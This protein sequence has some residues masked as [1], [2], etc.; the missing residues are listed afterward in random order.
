MIKIFLKKLIL[1]VPLIII[2]AVVNYGI[3]PGGIFNTS[4]S[5]LIAK[6]L[7]S[8]KNAAN[9][10]N[11]DERAFQ[12]YYIQ[13]LKKP[14][15]VVVLGSS[16]SMGVGTSILPANLS[17]FNS[18]VS[19]GKLEDFEAIYFLYKT[20]QMLPKVVILGVDPWVFNKFAGES[21]WTKLL[22]ERQ[23]M[24]RLMQ[25][26]FL[27]DDCNKTKPINYLEI[28]SLSYFQASVKSMIAGKIYRPW[29]YATD[30]MD[31]KT[32]IKRTDGTLSYPKKDRERDSAI[33]SSEAVAYAKKD[34]VYLLDNFTD[35]DMER[36][37]EF[38][39]FLDYLKQDNVAVIFFLPPYHP[40]A[41]KILSESVKY[42]TIVKA[43][44][45][46]RT[47]AKYRGIKVVG[48]YDPN[49]CGVTDK[50]F[51]DAAHIKEAPTVK[52]FK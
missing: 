3:D 7:L 39:R 32:E 11:F 30:E 8:G 19:G 18:F 41:Y 37:Y 48:S 12:K 29:L 28:L 47:L 24:M 31:G 21:R 5:A 17:L 34:S 45:L 23:E 4:K 9:I 42:K 27:E 6:I 10:S 14:K 16:R 52:L 35:L 2:I 25:L 51:L 20:A 50:D 33:I 40:E 22:C 36:A 49:F 38:S 46:L 15:D 44:I 13:G 26:P 43:E 1:F